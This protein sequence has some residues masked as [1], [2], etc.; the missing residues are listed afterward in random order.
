MS[1]VPAKARTMPAGS[2]RP[3]P[4]SAAATNVSAIPTVV[5]WFGVSGERARR[6]ASL[7]ALRLTHAWKRVVNT[8]FGLL[9]TRRAP[10]LSRLLIDLDHP[11]GHHRPRVPLGLRQGRLAQLTPQVRIASQNRE[12]HTQLT[13][14]FGPDGQAVPARFDHGQV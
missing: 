13:R 5:I 12:S 2:S 9:L 8:R 6:R 14:A 4:A 3:K 10:C 11:G 7:S 1:K